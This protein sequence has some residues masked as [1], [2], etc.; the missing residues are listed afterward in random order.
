MNVSVIVFFFAIIFVVGVIAALYAYYKR[1]NKSGEGK[2]SDIYNPPPETQNRSG[3][4]YL[5]ILTVL[6][7]FTCIIVSTVTGRLSVMQRNISDLQTSQDRLVRRIDELME[8]LEQGEKY[9]ESCSW[10]I[11]N[12]DFAS[13]T[14]D[15]DY[16]V[17]LRQ[18]TEGTQV[19]LS[20]N[21]MDIPLEQSSAGVYR[22]SYRVGLFD[23]YDM[24]IIRITEDGKTTTEEG[25]FPYYIF[26]Y[27]LPRPN[28]TCT[29]SSGGFLGKRDYK[30][31]YTL[32]AE[33]LE[34]V[35]S[36]TVTY[37]TSGR[38]LKTIDITEQ[39]LKEER[40]E[41]EEGLDLDKDLTFRIEINTKSG[42]KVVEQ[43]VMIYDTSV[44]H[45]MKDFMRVYDRD[46]K[47]LWDEGR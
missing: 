42:F 8:R 2:S 37:M 32:H 47:L 15:V 29:F 34:D 22:T 1:S 4:S 31:S 12:P 26:E 46:G 13:Y 3:G 23:T 9:V 17:R 33:P 44:S 36:V 10:E 35:Q 7:T 6:A 39:T 18:Y 27:I 45:E 25:D 5:V 41:L 40:I 30:G 19:V 20:L 24:P 16:T 28:L 43:T 38:D 14:A 11:L 21:G